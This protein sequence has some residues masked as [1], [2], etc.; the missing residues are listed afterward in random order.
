VTRLLLFVG[1]PLLELWLLVWLE[2]Q[3]GLGVTIVLIVLTG[4]V[5]ARLVGRQGRRVWASFLQRISSGQI[6]DVEIAHG[7]MLLVAG[8]FLVTP[9]VVTDLAGLLLL[10]PLVRERLRLR[11]SRVVRTVVV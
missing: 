11:F 8:A 1:L 3:V 5:G 6:P 10:V 9:G 2:G 4:L 7:A